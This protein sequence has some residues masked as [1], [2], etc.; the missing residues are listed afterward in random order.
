[1]AKMKNESYPWLIGHALV[2]DAC[3]ALTLF[4]LVHFGAVDYS[5][6]L[7]WIFLLISLSHLV[8]DY[9]KRFANKLNIKRIF[10]YDQLAHI[11]FIVIAWC[12]WGKNLSVDISNEITQYFLIL[13]GL[14]II[15]RPVGAFIERDEILGYDKNSKTSETTP[16]DKLKALSS[17]YKRKKQIQKDEAQEHENA[18]RWIGYLER[19]IIYI[20]LLYGQYTAIAFVITAKSIARFPEINDGKKRLQANYYIIGTLL[21][22]TSVFIVTILLGLVSISIQ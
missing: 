5:H 7:L 17:A 2:Y 13:L 8:I 6:D 16:L 12:L 21:S 10:T 9:L 3:I 20:L 11:A 19:I 1:M 14:L 15:I 22:V 18:S 4:S